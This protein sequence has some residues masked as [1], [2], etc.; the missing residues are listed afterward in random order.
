[1]PTLSYPL[2]LPLRQITLFEQ[3]PKRH[4]SNNRYKCQTRQSGI[5]T[6]SLLVCLMILQLERVNWQS[7]V[8]P[9]FFYKLRASMDEWR[10]TKGISRLA[11]AHL[12]P[13]C[14]KYEAIQT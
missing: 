11:S 9:L 4:N 2:L 14:K 12:P 8:A 7:T 1:M 3:K 6:Y 10:A 5:T 13:Y